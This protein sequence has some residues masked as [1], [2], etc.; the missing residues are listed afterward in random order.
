MNTTESNTGE[1]K[2]N[3]NYS[4]KDRGG[5]PSKANKI[6]EMDLSEF[7]RGAGTCGGT[8]NGTSKAMVLWLRSR[9]V[10]VTEKTCGRAIKKLIYLGAITLVKGAVKNS[11]W[12]L[13]PA[14]PADKAQPV[15]S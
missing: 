5:R 6:L 10:S 4:E 15:S 3:T 11:K 13:K 14:V 2:W 8:L 12:T 7:Y 1:Y 9:G